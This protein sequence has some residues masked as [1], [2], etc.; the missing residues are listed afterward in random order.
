MIKLLENKL[1]VYC[2]EINIGLSQSSILVSFSGGLDSTALSTAM[3]EIGRK[4]KCKLGLVHFN[5]NIHT[6]AD[7]AGKFCQ[8]FAPTN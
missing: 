3:V 4:Y 7:L 6:N 2:E 1:T 8:S 5:H